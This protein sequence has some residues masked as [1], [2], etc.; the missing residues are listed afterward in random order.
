MV[1]AIVCAPSAKR[2]MERKNLTIVRRE[3]HG[4]SANPEFVANYNYGK[5]KRTKTRKEEAE[6]R[7]A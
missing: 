3:I 1:V 2:E 7:K 5:Q 6:A 4:H